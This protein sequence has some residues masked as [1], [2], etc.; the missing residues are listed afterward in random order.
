MKKVLIALVVLITLAGAG[1]YVFQEP[2]K[3]MAMDKITADMYV[4][5]DNDNFDPGLPVGA[6]FPPIL[7]SLDGATITDVSQ[8]SGPNGLVFVANRSVDW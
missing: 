1:I 7:A 6:T 3:A 5:A 2:I 4:A 8:Y